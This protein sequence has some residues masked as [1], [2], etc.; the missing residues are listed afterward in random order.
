MI[1]NAK[2]IAA[3]CALLEGERVLREK[4]IQTAGK[5]GDG[6]Q[7]MFCKRCRTSWLVALGE[8]HSPYCLFA[9]SPHER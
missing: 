8:R 6:D 2:L 9:E 7:I 4:W 1:T 5:T 3:G